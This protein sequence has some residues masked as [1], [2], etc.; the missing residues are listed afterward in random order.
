MRERKKRTYEKKEQW[1]RRKYQILVNNGY[2]RSNATEAENRINEI[3]KYR[4]NGIRDIRKQE[5]GLGKGEM[6]IK[7]QKMEIWK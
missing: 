1:E 4:M 6:V 2:C 3:F 5:N 7:K